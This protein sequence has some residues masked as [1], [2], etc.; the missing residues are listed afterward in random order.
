[1]VIAHDETSCLESEK[2]ETDICEEVKTAASALPGRW[3]AKK[4]RSVVRKRSNVCLKVQHRNF[5]YIPKVVIDVKPREV[6]VKLG[7]RKKTEKDSVVDSKKID[8]KSASK[9]NENLIVYHRRKHGE[10]I[11]SWIDLLTQGIFSIIIFTIVASNLLVFSTK[12]SQVYVILHIWC[13]TKEKG[14]EEKG[15]IRTCG[16]EA[17]EK[18][19][20]KSG[21]S[22]LQR[23]HLR[24]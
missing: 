12:N 15:Q 8:Q 16:I 4:R 19:E 17:Y 24:L 20:R 18:E 6:P 11:L 2:C 22:T 13:R 14:D 9:S 21:Y 7:K 5:K 1:M 3:M 23:N 10:K